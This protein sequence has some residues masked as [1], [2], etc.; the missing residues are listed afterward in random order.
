MKNSMVATLAVCYANRLMDAQK[1]EEAITVIDSLLSMDSAIVGLHRRLL[2][3][4]RIFCELIGD[5]NSQVIEKLYDKEQ[6]KFMKQMA[7][8]PTV[9]RTEYVYE[10]IFK[11]DVKK[12]EQIKDKFEK[13]AKTY[14]Y[15]TDMESE[16]ADS[17]CFAQTN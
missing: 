15:S 10:L 9:I 12:A 4:D 13:C 6:V 5:R 3:C 7:K 17:N 2:I 8:F 11:G 16:R 1:F 14:P